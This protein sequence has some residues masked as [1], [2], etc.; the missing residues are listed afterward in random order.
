LQHCLC[1]LHSA[2]NLLGTTAPSSAMTQSLSKHP[3]VRPN[4]FHF[5]KISISLV[6]KEAKEP[7]AASYIAVAGNYTREHWVELDGFLLPI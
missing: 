6:Y 1:S 5:I 7:Q 4:S 2:A 3:A